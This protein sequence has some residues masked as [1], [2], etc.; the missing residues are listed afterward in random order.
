[1]LRRVG[2]E[3]LAVTDG[4]VDLPRRDAPSFTRP[5][6]MTAVRPWKK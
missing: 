3:L 4:A 5:W 2:G 6:E 1:V